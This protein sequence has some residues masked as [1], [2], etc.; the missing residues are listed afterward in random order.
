MTPNDL[1]NLERCSGCRRNTQHCSKNVSRVA[2]RSPEGHLRQIEFLSRI[3]EDKI[4][5]LEFVTQHKIKDL[6]CLNGRANW[7]RQVFLHVVDVV[8]SKWFGISIDSRS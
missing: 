3:S 2:L 8:D 1:N 5:I 7:Y 6:A 4:E